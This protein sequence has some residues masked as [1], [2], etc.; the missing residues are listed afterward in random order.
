MPAATAADVKRSNSEKKSKNPFTLIRS[1]SHHT[2]TRANSNGRTGQ[3]LSPP[4]RRS[5]S[6]ARMPDLSHNHNPFTQGVKE[7]F[8]VLGTG[9]DISG[10]RVPRTS[11]HHVLPTLSTSG[12]PKLP[13][14]GYPASTSSSFQLSSSRTPSAMSIA[15]QNGSASGAGGSSFLNNETYV[16][17]FPL[18]E[19][20][21]YLPADIHQSTETVNSLFFVNDQSKLKKLG[22]GGG[23]MVFGAQQKATHKWFAIKKLYLLKHETPDHFYHRAA[24]EFIIGQGLSGHRHIIGTYALLKVQTY[25]TIQ[26]G[27]AICLEFCKHGDLYDFIKT[28]HYKSSGLNEKFCFFKQIAYGLKF[29]QDCGISH[30]DMKPENILI[31]QDACLKIT[32]FGIADYAHEDPND[33]SSPLKECKTF[34]GSPPYVPPEAMDLKDPT[35][36]SSYIMFDQDNWALGMILFVLIYGSQPFLSASNTDAMYRDWTVS[37]ATLCNSTPAFRTADRS[38]GPGYEFKWAKEF[39][40]TGAARVAW[41]LLDPH[42]STRYKL[43]DV[44]SDPWFTQVECCIDEEDPDDSSSYASV[45]ASMFVKP[46]ESRESSSAPSPLVKPKS[47]LDLD[48]LSPSSN[49]SLSSS[50]I[51]GSALSPGSNHG[52][53]PLVIP[54]ALPTLDEVEAESIATSPITNITKSLAEASLSE[55]EKTEEEHQKTEQQPPNV[56]NDKQNPNGTPSPTTPSSLASPRVQNFNPFASNTLSYSSGNESGDQSPELVKRGSSFSS[57][58]SRGSAMSI[59]GASTTRRK[60]HNHLP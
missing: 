4:V 30:R 43:E 13:M 48:V 21:S 31:D 59:R 39:K 47:M 11:N 45:C 1:F 28:N 27:W 54:K 16:L 50:Q 18:A 35:K 53:E 42:L 36:K 22:S 44:L 14:A 49:K 24:R 60:K 8:D 17:P 19:P 58:H 25:T 15:T 51:N 40:S 41:R 57:L 32:D 46:E 29:M 7:T 56:D 55:E 34:V 52:S 20:N 6:S 10:P 26:R 3:P 33:L 38:H 23:A 5:T 37:Y 9:A 12:L 2:R